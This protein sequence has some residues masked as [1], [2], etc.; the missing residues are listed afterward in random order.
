VPNVSEKYPSVLFGR[1]P[2]SSLAS[3]NG[4][5]LVVRGL[6]KGD[7]LFFGNS[8]MMGDEG[9]VGEKGVEE[10]LPVFTTFV[11]ESASLPGGWLYI[12]VATKTVE[13][14][15]TNDGVMRKSNRMTEA[16]KEMMMERLVA[17]PFRMLS[18]Y[19]ITTAVINP[20]NT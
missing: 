10:F 19:L 4:L 15:I 8:P 1:D 11:M 5:A 6:P 9:L 20:P 3:P 14:P 18:E 16:R 7:D 13:E 17:N 2:V 12:H